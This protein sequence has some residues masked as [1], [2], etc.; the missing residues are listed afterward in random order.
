MGTQKRNI[1]VHS[2]YTELQPTMAPP[3][4]P[5][6]PT[7]CRFQISALNCTVTESLFQ[8]WSLP[9]LRTSFECHFL[10]KASLP[11]LSSSFY[12]LHSTY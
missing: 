7:L 4:F 10:T 8:H 11:F 9:F 12:F 2:S 5:K 1:S 6:R 3:K